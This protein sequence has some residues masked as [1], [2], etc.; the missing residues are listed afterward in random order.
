MSRAFGTCEFL[1]ANRAYWRKIST[2]KVTETDRLPQWVSKL[3]I[4][5]LWRSGVGI[6]VEKGSEIQDVGRDY[7][8]RNDI[9]GNESVLYFLKCVKK[10]FLLTSLNLT[11]FSSI[12]Q[13]GDT[14]WSFIF[15]YAWSTWLFAGYG[16]DSTL[17]TVCAGSRFKKLP[18][19]SVSMRG[20]GNILEAVGIE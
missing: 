9:Q 17:R 19:R 1:L 14:L 4:C 5:L 20:W 10:E 12:L 16:Q 11:T 7:L 2:K 6:L 8:F 13:R 18:S 3:V 15:Y